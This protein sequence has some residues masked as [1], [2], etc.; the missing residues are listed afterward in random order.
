MALKILYERIGLGPEATEEQ[1]VERIHVLADENKELRVKCDTLQKMFA[2][3]HRAIEQAKAEKK[4]YTELTAFAVVDKAIADQ[5]I[6]AHQR[7]YFL[8]DFIRDP[9][10]TQKFFEEQGYRS[11]L[12]RRTSLAGDI[13]PVSAL[14]EIEGRAAEL[15]ARD[16][17]LSKSE[18]H[19]RVLSENPEL[20]DRYRTA[21]VKG[22]GGAD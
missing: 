5:R 9:E 15:I 20:A 18:A 19:Q 4:K 21:V 14:V 3:N 22:A 2:E 1:A 7:E 6:E 12:A 13:A 17:K 10:R 16:G 8:A 11:I